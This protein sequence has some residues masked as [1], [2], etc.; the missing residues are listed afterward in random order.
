[1]KH[2]T[3]PP[4]VPAVG[5][6]YRV[7]EPGDASGIVRL[8][9]N[10]RIQPLPEWFMEGLRHRLG[11]H[12]ITNY[13]ITDHLYSR[14]SAEL[15]V[16]EDKLL[17]TAGSDAAVKALFHAYVRPGD[18]V[19]IL[20][21]S[22][23]MYKVYSE[24]FQAQAVQ[25]SFNYDLELD[26]KQLIESITPGVRLVMIANPNQPTG[27]LMDENVLLQ[28]AHRAG[29]VGALLAVDEA[30]YPFSRTTV[31]P[32][33]RDIPHLLVIRTFSKAAGLAGLRVGFVVAHREV[34]ANLFKVRSVHD[35]SSIAVL[36]A[37]EVLSHPEI[38]D[39]YVAQVEEGKRF[40]ADKA[41]ELGLKSLPTCTNFMQIRVGHVCSPADLV[42][43]LYRNGY[44]VRGPFH[45]PC[46][47]GCIRVTLG[48]LEAMASF[49]DAFKKAFREL[50]VTLNA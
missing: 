19:L 26:A 22:Y 17:L 13:P 10:E 6:L 5:N 36:A 12:L 31:L 43:H 9:R 11:S 46:L 8:N 38:V 4:P 27:T 50:G 37:S 21:P 1:M 18:K 2:P 48:P 29:N 28:M 33:V 7:R 45:A 30:Y 23:A 3:L 49:L 44:L 14:L 40:L 47:A 15:D 16:D 24:M 42:D 35:V 39:D 41:R 20:D 25:V 34:V 32:L